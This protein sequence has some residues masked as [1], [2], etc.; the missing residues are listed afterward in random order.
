MKVKK[1]LS[2]SDEKFNKVQ[3]RV[4]IKRDSE[5]Q[6]PLHD[7]DQV[8]YFH[9]LITREFCGNESDR[10]YLS[11]FVEI[12]DEDG[13]GTGHFKPRDGIVCFPVSA[14]IHG[15]IAFSL[16]SGSHFP[17]QQWDVTR[18][19]AYM[20]TDKKRFEEMCCKNGWMTVPDENNPETRRPAKDFSEFKEYLRKIA[21]R[22]L[23]TLQKAMDGD[24]WGYCEKHRKPFKRVYPDG[25]EID[26]FGSEV[27]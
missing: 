9:S 27:L 20:W 1:I 18:G 14:Y 8:F 13:Y 5:P 12:L 22:E 19:A 16:G 23:N 11:P 4:I 2:T 15:G 26:D 6:D 24:V 25:T 10:K 21:K 17:D 7:W 3:T